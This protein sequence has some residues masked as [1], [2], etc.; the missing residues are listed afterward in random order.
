MAY[1]F[2]CLSTSVSPPLCLCVVSIYLR[3]GTHSKCLIEEVD[4]VNVGTRLRRP[5]VTFETYTA[6]CQV[7]YSHEVTDPRECIY[8]WARGRERKWAGMPDSWL[9][10]CPVLSTHLLVAGEQ[11][12][13]QTTIL[14]YCLDLTGCTPKSTSPSEIFPLDVR[15]HRADLAR[16][17]RVSEGIVAVVCPKGEAQRVS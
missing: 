14:D 1:S 6:V 15:K 3:F 13:K 9:C 4:V 10:I 11:R 17:V 7:E 2:I 5:P 16:H 12:K 8:M